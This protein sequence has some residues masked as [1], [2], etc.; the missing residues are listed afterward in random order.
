LLSSLLAS[1]LTIMNDGMLER[2]ISCCPAGLTDCKQDV[3]QADMP[4][5]LHDGWH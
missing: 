3:L 1:N 2:M 5:S 4:D